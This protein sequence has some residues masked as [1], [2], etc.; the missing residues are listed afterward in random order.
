MDSDSTENEILT[1]DNRYQLKK[2]KVQKEIEAAQRLIKSKV[3]VLEIADKF[4][5]N[6][7]KIMKEG[8]SNR[9]NKLTEEEIQNKI[10]NILSFKE[11]FKSMKQRYNKPG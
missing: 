8:M 9:N 10:R 5:H 1:R 11:K 6:T 7:F 3:E 4:I 2:Q